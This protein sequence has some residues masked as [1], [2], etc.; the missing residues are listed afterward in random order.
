MLSKI[1]WP[2]VL[3]VIV[4]LVVLGLVAGGRFRKPITG[5]G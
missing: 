2:T 3:A 4:I 1:S 5:S